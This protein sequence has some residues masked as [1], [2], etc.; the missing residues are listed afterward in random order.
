MFNF[1]NK[2][3]N[4][5]DVTFNF[6]QFDVN[7]PELPGDLIKQVHE[8]DLEGFIIENVLTQ[9]EVAKAI[10]IFES[11]PKELILDTNTGD[12]FPNPFATLSHNLEKYDEYVGKLKEFN[13]LP[14]DFLI[15][16]LEYGLKKVGRTY[17]ISKPQLKD[18]SGKAVPTTI[19]HF[20]PD[21]GG[22]YVHCGYY[23]QENAPKYY[24]IVEPMKK[25]GQLS[26]FLVLQRP[27]E[28]GQLT[29][30]D[31]VWEKVN[32]KTNFTDNDHVLDKNGKK[33]DLRDVNKKHFNPAPGSLLVFYGGKIWHRV[34][35][36]KGSKPRITSGGFLNF[37]NDEKKIF[38]WG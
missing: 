29:L 32:G 15:E 33:I 38:Y 28:G 9:E 30:Y 36:I 31:M 12:I 6:K 2:Q 5:G 18:H 13:K 10:E 25:D 27:D 24:E 1:F 3:Y 20:Y 7:D 4:H 16:K 17:T 23:F 22:L 21:K 26:Y 37:S 14:L 35:N 34:E 19:R 11:I 8:G